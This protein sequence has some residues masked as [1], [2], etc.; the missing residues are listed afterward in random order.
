MDLLNTFLIFNLTA[1]LLVMSGFF[2]MRENVVATV[3]NA[4]AKVAEFNMAGAAG[5][6]TSLMLLSSVAALFR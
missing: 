2:L 6:A 3:A 1:T 4:K 5:A